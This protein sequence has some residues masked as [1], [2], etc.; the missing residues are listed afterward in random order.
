MARSIA[1]RGPDG[2]DW[3]TTENASL[4]ASR[5]AIVGDFQASA[6]FR[7]EQTN[8]RVL[9]NGEIYNVD[10]L[11]AELLI[12]GFSFKT[13]LESEVIANLYHLHGLNFPKYL[14]GMFAI[15]ILDGDRLVLARDRFGI[16]PMYYSI[17]G[18]RVIF[19]SEIKSILAY[20]G[21]VARLHIPALE[22]TSVFGYI[23]SS[24]KTLFQDIL[25]VKPGTV[26]TFLKNNR[27]EIRFCEMPDAQ[28]LDQIRHQSFSV[29]RTKLR[30]LIIDTID[31]LFSHGSQPKGIYLSGGIDSTILA[32]VA[33]SILGYPVTTF[34]LADSTDSPDFL[35][36]REV[37][38]KLGTTHIEHIVSVKDY[39]NELDHFVEHYESL[40]AGGVFDIHGGMAFHLLSKVVSEHVKVAFSGEGADELFGGYYWV[41][42]HP[43]GFSDRI[44]SRLAVCRNGSPVKEL[45]ERLFPLPED[46]RVYRLNLFNALVKEGLA[47]YHL[48]SV[49]RSAGAFGFEIRP[50]YLYD[51]LA[52]FALNLP[53]DYKVPDKNT[54]KWILREAFRPEL[55]RLGLGWVTT[56]LK[57]GMPA[58]V[59]NLAP[60][61]AE[62][63]ESSISDS[64]LAEHPLRAYLRSKTDLF[65]FDIFARTFL[66]EMNYAV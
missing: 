55:E 66:P 34:T 39:F 61:I 48:Q 41:Y 15:A 40:V 26:L 44:R 19:G 46:E 21:F 27:S 53:I 5:L 60:L 58:A 23:S 14:K 18:D 7:D 45:V 17:V 52:T 3:V 57:E 42:T 43:L 29:A 30:N 9:L 47:N 11:R 37:A 36:A 64:T 10:A 1:H 32:L 12:K 62:R 33:R 65:L 22:E 20:P 50:A 4:G 6:I 35:A 38:K 16:K 63:M 13:D 49:D 8:I 51:D 31:L 24:E 56:R 28:Y 25:Q 59:A 54:T 2:L